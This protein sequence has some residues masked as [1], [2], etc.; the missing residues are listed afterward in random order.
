MNTDYTRRTIFFLLPFKTIVLCLFISL[1]L[2]PKTSLAEGTVDFRDYSGYRLFLFAERYQQLKVYASEG[3]FIN[4]ASSHVGIVG[5]TMSIYRPDGTLHTTFDNTG[6]TEGLAIINNDVEELNGPTGGGTTMG[7]GYVPG[8][9]SVGAGEGGVWT[10]LLEYPFY[11]NT[12]FANLLNSESWNRL[13]DLPD[14]NQ[15]DIGNHLQ[16]VERR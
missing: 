3:E 6:A 12:G 14:R 15:F 5:G 10:V 1:F 8:V 7:P 11:N 9:I 4:L 16:L 2:F 13:V